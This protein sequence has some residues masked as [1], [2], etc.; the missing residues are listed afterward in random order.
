MKP[1][2]GTCRMNDDHEKKEK[3][4][5]ED[6]MMHP[7]SMR[8][9]DSENTWANMY[10]F[11]MNAMMRAAGR[12]GRLPA[13]D[14]KEDGS[15][16]VILMN[17]P[18]VPKEHVTITAEDNGLKVRTAEAEKNEDETLKT[19]YRERMSGTYEREFHFEEP[20]DVENVSASMQNGVLELTVPK[21][22]QN[23]DAKTIPVQ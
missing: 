18:G 13:T 21:K 11:R 22:T 8:K 23:T 17:M 16:Y 10:P 3:T 6:L 1:M 12:L 20:V 7:V 15:R 2:A 4:M 5:Y 14:I 19:V 9:C